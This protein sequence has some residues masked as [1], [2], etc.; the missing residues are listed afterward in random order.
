[1]DSEALF[2]G[3][4]ALGTVLSIDDEIKSA[5]KQAFGVSEALQFAREK[6][7][8]ENRVKEVIAEI[9]SLLLA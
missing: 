4:I 5:A 3:L 9:E 6:S 2:R 8:K 1:M 7:G